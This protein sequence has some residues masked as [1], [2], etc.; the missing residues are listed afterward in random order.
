MTTG[1]GCDMV[2]TKDLVSAYTQRFLNL[3]NNEEKIS[4]DEFSNEVFTAF[5]DGISEEIIKDLIEDN[6]SSK[7]LKAYLLNQLK[8]LH[9]WREKD[10]RRRCKTSC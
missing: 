10:D 5:A 4:F 6:I 2:Q 7:I 1:G 3:A 8:F 9:D